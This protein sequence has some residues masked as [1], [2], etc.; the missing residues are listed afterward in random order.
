[1]QDNLIINIGELAIPFGM[2]FALYALKGKTKSKTSKTGKS[3]SKK[4]TK[5]GGCSLCKGGGCNSCKQNQH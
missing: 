2:M 3:K 4:V 5:G 1:M